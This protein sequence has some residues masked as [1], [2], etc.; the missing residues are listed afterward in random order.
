MVYEEELLLTYRDIR[1]KAS[2]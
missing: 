1:E 2:S